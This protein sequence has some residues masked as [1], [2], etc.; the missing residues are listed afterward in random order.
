MLEGL[1]QK[2][3]S[4]LN[5]LNIEREAKVETPVVKILAHWDNQAICTQ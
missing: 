3:W 4:M 2:G 5:L 1:R